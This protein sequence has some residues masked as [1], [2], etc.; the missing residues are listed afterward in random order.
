[1]ATDMDIDMDLDL[2]SIEDDAMFENPVVCLLPNVW[3][4]TASH[5]LYHDILADKC[6]AAIN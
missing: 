1:M 4:V 6:A 3:T 2:G 5:Q